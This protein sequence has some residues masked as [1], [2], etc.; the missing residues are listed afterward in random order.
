M[1][2]GDAKEL[3][4]D[5]KGKSC[6]VVTEDVSRRQRGVVSKK[7]GRERTDV[8]AW[9]IQNMT[10]VLQRAGRRREDMARDVNY[11][12]LASTCSEAGISIFTS[13]VSCWLGHAL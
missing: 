4:R 7:V 1:P 6:V 13:Y 3:Q 5:A 11:L 8:H 9:Y 10:G 2:R 12:Y